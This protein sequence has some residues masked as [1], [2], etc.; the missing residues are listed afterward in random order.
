MSL[1]WLLLLLLRHTVS[2]VSGFVSRA[3]TTSPPPAASSHFPKPIA[4]VVPSS[5]AETPPTSQWQT[6]VSVQSD[7]E[8]AVDELT[9]GLHDQNPDLAFLFVSQ[10]HGS[11]FPVLVQQLHQ[12][13]ACRLLSV[14]GSG[15]IGQDEELEEPSKPSI[16]LMVGYH[17]RT[18]NEAPLELFHFNELHKPPPE[19]S[20]AYWDHLAQGNQPNKEAPSCSVLIFAD[21]WSPV[22]NVTA[23]LSQAV[24]A[25]GISCPTGTGPTVALDDRPLP[26]GSLVGVRLPHRLQLQVVTA[27]G[28]RPVGDIFIITAA[29]GSVILELN[30]QPALQVLESM[31][32]EGGS[33]SQPLTGLVCGL[34]QQSQLASND[35]MDTTV[36]D[37]SQDYL[38]RQIIGFVPTKGGIAV[39]GGVHVGDRLRF[40]VRDKQAARQDL[41]LMLQRAQT[42]RTVFGGSG[43]KWV[44]ALQF[45]CV[46]RGRSFFGDRNVDLEQTKSLLES[47]SPVAGF[48]A[49]GELGPVGIAG[50]AT[51]GSL[52]RGSHIHGFTTVVAYICDTMGVTARR[53]LEPVLSPI[54]DDPSAWE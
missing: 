41:G 22:E 51:G 14:M 30:G 31:V 5:N 35:N 37:P 12:R 39:P 42:E 32:Q 52:V 3:A 40:H 9:N 16:S 47:D 53:E 24:I 18:D 21:P 36:L 7:L 17:L 49:N 10:F 19:P 54:A 28:C 48:Y 13:L 15:V 34:Q 25:G 44:G 26:Q 46:A 8:Q 4:S 6:L 23:A 33:S 11:N 43:G 50:F 27:Q 45:S 29:E 2:F 20:S 1:L 38:I